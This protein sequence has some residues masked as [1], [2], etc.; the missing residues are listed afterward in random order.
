MTQQAP[1]L[2]LCHASLT[3][4]VYAVVVVVGVQDD[5]QADEVVIVAEN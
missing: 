1:A 5:T 3:H 2:A 4:V